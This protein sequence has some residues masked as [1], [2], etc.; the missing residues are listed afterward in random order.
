VTLARARVKAAA[1]LMRL[2]TQLR[3]EELAAAL[4][5]VTHGTPMSFG[6]WA[7]AFLNRIGAPVARNNLVAVVAWQ[8]AEYTAARWNPL[9]TTYP[10]PGSTSFNRSR[11]RNYVSLS[12]GLQA[13]ISTLGHRGYGYEAILA[14]LAKN[15]DPMT[16]A[17]AINASR[18]CPGCV[19][20]RYVID[21]VPSVEQYYD[22]YAHS[23][24]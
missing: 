15:A 21:L 20:G 22:R 9:A 8:T 14:G 16:T 13:T 6:R 11:V 7:A 17:R 18:W 5:A 12:Q 3:T 24:T 1:L 10:M 2:R 23:S 19:N 4:R